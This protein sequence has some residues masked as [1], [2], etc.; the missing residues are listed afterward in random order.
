MPYDHSTKIGNQGDVVKH[1]ALFAALRHLLQGW[2]ADREFVYADIHAG[3]PQYVLP[4]KGEWRS[5]IGLFSTLE[6]IKNDRKQRK[7]GKRT[8]LGFVGDFDDMIVG[9][10]IT[11]GMFYPGSAGMAFRIL[12]VSN[13]RFSM[14]LWEEDRAAADDS[15]RFFYPWRKRV[16]TVCGDGYEVVKERKAPSF[17]LIDPPRIEQATDALRTMQQLSKRDVPFLCWMPRTPKSVPP[18]DKEASEDWSSEEAATSKDYLSLAAQHGKCLRILWKP[19]WGPSPGCS[20][21]VY[22]RLALDVAPAIKQVTE[23]MKWKFE[24]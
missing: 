14:K 18:A 17:V 9:R 7:E 21:T 2:S 11:T 6:E 23:W 15:E 5:G 4:E 8:R 1:I 10:P 3:R 12:R 16:R 24:D 22:D 19:K 13:T 20:I